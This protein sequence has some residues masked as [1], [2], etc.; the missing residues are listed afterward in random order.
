MFNAFDKRQVTNAA[1]LSVQLTGDCA[2]CT[3]AL[4]GMCTAHA[5]PFN[6]PPLNGT[7]FCPAGGGIDRLIANLGCSCKAT[8]A[9][10]A[11]SSTDNPCLLYDKEFGGTVV[12]TAPFMT[13]AA[14]ATYAINVTQLFTWVTSIFFSDN[15]GTAGARH[16]GLTSVS[17][18]RYGLYSSPATTNAL[19]EVVPAVPNASV[20]ERALAS[21]AAGGSGF[22]GGFNARIVERA[23]P[24]T[25]R[26]ACVRACVPGPC[27]LTHV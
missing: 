26:G 12:D 25:G 15:T 22:L 8:G 17:N 10:C 13:N 5:P 23:P 21:P 3:R 20:W 19:G 27:A 7:G 6:A 4:R 11:A 24:V 9:V 1:A 14:F 18:S 2:T 16:G